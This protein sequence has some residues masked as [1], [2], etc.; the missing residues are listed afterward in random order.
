MRLRAVA[1]DRDTAALMG[2]PVKR[3]IAITFAGALAL[4]GL[5]GVL[6]APVFFV[7]PEVGGV[8]S[9]RAFCASIV[10]GFGSL[11]GA[12]AGG[13]LLGVAETLGGAYIS[14]AFRDGIA[15]ILLI[16]VLVFRPSGLFGEKTGE[17]A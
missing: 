15:F 2:I 5:G 9:L 13:L 14:Q 4:A 8:I 7:H 1:Q 17:R 11:P 6:L 3:M 10:G 12:I 16:A